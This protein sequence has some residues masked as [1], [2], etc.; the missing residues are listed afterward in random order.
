MRQVAYPHAP[1][2]LDSRAEQKHQLAARL[3]R[4]WRG[5]KGDG[6]LNRLK[7][8]AQV[9]RQHA[10]DLGERALNR[11]RVGWEPLSPRGNKTEQYRQGFVVGQHQRRRLEP[12]PQTITALK[13]TRPLYPA[14]QILQHPDLP[15]HHP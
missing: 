13:S 10:L 6:R 4:G 14:A 5:E 3:R 2:L 7:P 15:P 1:L 12:P 11:M 9:V 8:Y